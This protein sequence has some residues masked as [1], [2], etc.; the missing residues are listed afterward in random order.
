MDSASILMKHIK[1]YGD[2]AKIAVFLSQHFAPG[3]KF[4]HY[5]DSVCPSLLREKGGIEIEGPEFPAILMAKL[6]RASLPFSVATSTA[7][8][9]FTTPERI[10]MAGFLNRAY[11]SLESILQ[12]FPEVKTAD[13]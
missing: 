8:P 6:D 11:S 10:R 5:S 9:L 12:F 13:K 7:C 4:P 1:K 3:G 2:T